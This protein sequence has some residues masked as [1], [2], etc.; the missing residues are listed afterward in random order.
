MA[1]HIRTRP[2]S[3]G[4]QSLYID[5]GTAA[6]RFISLN[7]YINPGKD[8]ATKKANKEA[9]A[10]AKQK[11]SKIEREMSFPEIYTPEELNRIKRQENGQIGVLSFIQSNARKKKESNYQVWKATAKHLKW[12]WGGTEKKFRELT[13]LDVDE[14]QDYLLNTAIC[15]RTKKPISHN[16]AA[17][18]FATFKSILTDAFRGD[19]LYED[20]ANQAGKIAPKEVNREYLT[21]DELRRLKSAF[22]SYLGLK[23]MAL[24]SAYTGLR[25]S[26]VSKLKVSELKQT[27]DGWVIDFEQKK[28]GREEILPISDDAYNLLPIP[29]TGE[30]IF[31]HVDYKDMQIPLKKWI[32]AAG[33]KKHI[34]FHS[35]RHSF[36]MNM[37]AH[38]VDIVTISSML[39]HASISTTQVYAKALTAEKRA[40]TLQIKI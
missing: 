13:L 35:F 36:A 31:G 5:K 18:Y 16:S 1:I 7:L 3:R 15:A 28:T 4:R 30:K 29:P 23:E 39:G 14:F 26:D 10:L 25:W 20:L 9:L 12:C 19:Y 27:P 17:C 38:K 33:I 24:F 21:I 8:K 11:A 6:E 2:I 37:L 32:V 22:C 34:T 40:A